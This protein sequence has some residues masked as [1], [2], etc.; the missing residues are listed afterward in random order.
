MGPVADRALEEQVGVTPA[1]ETEASKA[2]IK[3]ICNIAAQ[4]QD[5]ITQDVTNGTD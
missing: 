5:F 1:E 4:E 3:A 2:L